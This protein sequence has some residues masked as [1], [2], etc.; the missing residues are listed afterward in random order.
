MALREGEQPVNTLRIASLFVFYSGPCK[1][2]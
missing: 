2:S 1:S